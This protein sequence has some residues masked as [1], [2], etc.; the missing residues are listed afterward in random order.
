MKDSTCLDFFLQMFPIDL[1]S[2]IVEQIHLYFVEVVSNLP[3]I[4]HLVTD[5]AQM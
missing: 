1:V 4:L 2:H 5:M 3:Y